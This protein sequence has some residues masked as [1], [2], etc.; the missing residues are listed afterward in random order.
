LGADQQTGR[1]G[2]DVTL[3]AFDFLCCIKAARTTGLSASL[4]ARHNHRITTY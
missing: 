3:A 2:H 4:I 1:V